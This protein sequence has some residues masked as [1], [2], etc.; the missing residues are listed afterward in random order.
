MSEYQ[1]RAIQKEN[2]LIENQF[3]DFIHRVRLLKWF[4]EKSNTFH[5]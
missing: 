4:S 2:N 1:Q 5:Q 3:G